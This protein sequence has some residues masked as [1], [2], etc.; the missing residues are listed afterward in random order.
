MSHSNTRAVFVV[1]PALHFSFLRD[2]HSPERYTHS[3]VARKCVHQL[4]LH[5]SNYFEEETLSGASPLR[6]GAIPVYLYRFFFHFSLSL[7]R[8]STQMHTE[9]TYRVID[10]TNGA[11]RIAPR[12]YRVAR[13]H[14]RTHFERK[15]IL[16]RLRN[17]GLS[18]SY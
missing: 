14:S 17:G 9:R 10:T 3:R 15:S 11:H 13:P 8:V 7:V 12:S 1:S 16:A 6:N 18:K 4:Y 5:I 2:T